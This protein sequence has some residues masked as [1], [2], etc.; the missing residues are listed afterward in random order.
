MFLGPARVIFVLYES[1]APKTNKPITIKRKKIMLDANRPLM[2]YYCASIPEGVWVHPVTGEPYM[3]ARA[4]SSLLGIS[5]ADIEE[6]T[7]YRHTGLYAVESVKLDETESILY[8]RLY[9]IETV[10]ATIVQYRW[11]IF[12]G[13]ATCGMLPL[14]YTMV[15][16]AGIPKYLSKSPHT[17]NFGDTVKF[18][19]D[20]DSARK[21]VQEMAAPYFRR[22]K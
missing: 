16:F 1:V 12:P 13:V 5:M 7:R 10:L 2:P 11:D 15:G 9:S 14:I 20:N 6:F 19:T 17:K 22:Q 4:M 3:S 8:V 21:Y 18:L